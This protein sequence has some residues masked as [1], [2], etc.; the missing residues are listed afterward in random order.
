[1]KIFKNEQNVHFFQIRDCD[2]SK[3]KCKVF[4]AIQIRLGLH[5]SACLQLKVRD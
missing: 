3:G 5:E 2:D 4:S 1:M